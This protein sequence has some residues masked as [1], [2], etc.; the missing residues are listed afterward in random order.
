MVQSQN[1]PITRKMLT[2][3]LLI[4]QIQMEQL[5]K[6]TN[7]MLSVLKRIL[8]IL[9]QTLSVT[10]VSIMT[11]KQALYTSEQDAMTHLMVDLLRGIV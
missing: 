11:L 1:I 9:I 4:L 8:T 6:P 10:A 7:T 3:M 5:L 2:G